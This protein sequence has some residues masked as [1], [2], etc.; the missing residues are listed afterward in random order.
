M[1]FGKIGCYA[2]VSLA[3]LGGFSS[4][5]SQ[6]LLYPDMFSLSEV[7][8]LDG[9]LKDRQDLNV[10]TLLSYDVDRLLAPFYEEA[11]MKPKASKFPNCGARW[12]CSRSLLECSCHALCR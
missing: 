6:D 3:L 10:E 1:M 12:P 9:P 4:A 7:Q 5:F 8:L 2:C 11:G